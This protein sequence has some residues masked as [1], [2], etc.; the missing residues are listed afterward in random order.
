MTCPPL[1]TALKIFCIPGSSASKKSACNTEDHSLIP[2][3]GR[4]PG[5]GIGYPP[6]FLGFSSGSDSKQFGCNTGN[7]GLT[8]GWGRYPGEGNV[9]P[10]QCSGLEIPWTEEPWQATVQGVTKN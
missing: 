8:P 6:L 9:Y 7:P 4:S 5:K 2:G 3:L 1:V 10:L